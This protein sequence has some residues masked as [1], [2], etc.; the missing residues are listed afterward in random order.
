MG[1]LASVGGN[2]HT[3]GEVGLMIN[4]RKSHEIAWAYDTVLFVVAITT[5]LLAIYV[6]WIFWIGLVFLAYGIFIEPRRLTVKRYREKLVHH[7]GVSVRLIFLSDLHAG[8]FKKHDWYERIANEAQALDPDILIMGGDY[9][10]D[11]VDP[12][13]DLEPIGKVVARLG[14]YFVLGNHDLVDDPSQI[15]STFSSW[16]LTDITNQTLKIR[17]EG[18]ELQLT[19]Q[20]DH[21]YGRPS[22]PPFERDS[23]LPHI[24]IAHEPDAIL[25]FKKDD[26]DL[27]MSGHSHGG[28]IQIPFIGPL[29][30]I[31]AKLGRRVDRGRKVINGV[32]IIVSQGLASSDIR[33]RFLCPPQIVVIELGI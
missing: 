29:L 15:R 19:G 13:H 12:I 28:Q 32:P 25:D 30:P 1:L 6:S 24:T 16:G 27:I 17:K 23:K 33:P 7:P 22:V 26:T 3:S 2:C 14:R 21:W 4:L 10:A 20:D 8:G 31:P 18:H 11:L 5:I 9:V